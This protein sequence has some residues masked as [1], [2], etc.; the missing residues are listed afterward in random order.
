MTDVNNKIDKQLYTINA[1]VGYRFNQTGLGQNQ[2]QVRTC[3]TKSNI[4][5]NPYP[6]F[7]VRFGQVMWSKSNIAKSRNT[8]RI[9]RESAKHIKKMKK[10]KRFLVWFVQLDLNG[11]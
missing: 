11:S 2:I 4:G 6:V 10:K 7:W 3:R 9:K 5:Q 1:S 8:C